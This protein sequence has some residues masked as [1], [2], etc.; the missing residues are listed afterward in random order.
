[1]TEPVPLVILGAAGR[2]GRA[3]IR[4]AQAEPDMRLV[5]AIERVDHGAIG[6]D[7]GL[8]AGSDP[9]GVAVTDNLALLPKRA[10]WIDFTNPDA[11]RAHIAQAQGH[12]AGVVIGTTGLGGADDTAIRRLAELIPVL[13]AANFSLGITILQSVVERVAAAL[14]P[15]ADIEIVEMHHRAKRDAPSGTALALGQAAARGR[16]V[17]LEDVAERGRDGLD[18]V[19]REGAIGFASLRGG[20]VVGDHSV[21]F[22]LAGE[23][24]ELTHRAGDRDLFAIGALKAAH[25]IAGRAPG[26]YVLADL[27]G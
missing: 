27:V 12:A 19:R 25:W 6:Q 26:R 16:G 1:M 4:G 15:E 24:I 17:R 8:L 9:L 13:Q 2:M 5:G 21:I 23:R 3:L 10:I 14:G 22:A 7:A 18:A 20:D 11:T